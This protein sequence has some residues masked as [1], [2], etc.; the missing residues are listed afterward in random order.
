[1][2]DIRSNSAS[3]SSSPSHTVRHTARHTAWR[4]AILRILWCEPFWIALLAPALLFPGRFWVAGLQPLWVLLLFAFWPLRLLAARFGGLRTFRASPLD[5]A[6]A[7]LLAAL[8][9]ALAVSPAPASSW[10][11]AGYLLLGVAAA[12]AL[13]QWP[14]AQRRPALVAWILLA[15]GGAIAA[16]GPLLLGSHADK[17]GLGFLVPGSGSWTGA[18]AETV[19]PNVLG[20]ALLVPLLLALALAVGPRW[21][22]QP[23]RW[24]W[25]MLF[26]AFAAELILTECRGAWLGAAAGVVVILL[27]R[28]PRS[29]WLLL[30]LGGLVAIGLLSAGAITLVFDAFGAAAAARGGDGL[31]D[32]IIIWQA[33][34]AAIGRQPLNGLGLGLFG[35]WVTQHGLLAATTIP[36]HAHN[37]LLQ[38]AADLGLGGLGAYLAVL[39]AAGGMLVAL[40]RARPLHWR[41][42]GRESSRRSSPGQSGPAPAARR[43][44]VQ[45][46]PPGEVHRLRLHWTLAVGSAGALVALLV[47]GLVDAALWGNKAAALPW[48]LIALVCLLFLAQQA[49]SRPNHEKGMRVSC[50][51]PGE[52]LPPP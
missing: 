51:P 38:V 41:R 27:L 18:L 40:L 37:L 31:A 52:D 50:M 16:V 17:L 48:L 30:P 33:A 13:I 47:H 8:G 14:P 25:G 34:V 11:A 1:M 5:L 49:S 6:L 46:L 24:V 20:G 36:L 35:P 45:H 21:S 12:A 39:L 32:R 22:R 28:W 26:V 2:Q 23:W 10:E 43:A 9:V 29:G 3:S 42:H 44:S 19:N 15:M 4:T 7:A